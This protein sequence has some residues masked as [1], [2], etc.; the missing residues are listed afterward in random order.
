MTRSYCKCLAW[1]RASQGPMLACQ[2]TCRRWLCRIDKQLQQACLAHPS[3]EYAGQDSVTVQVP[4]LA[5][6]E[7]G[8]DASLSEDL[9]ALAACLR[10]FDDQLEQARS[11]LYMASNGCYSWSRCGSPAEGRRGSVRSKRRLLA[12]WR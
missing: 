8:P 4:G 6:G 7:P 10:K 9:Q 1:H 12:S 5:Q 3:C 2:R 11:E